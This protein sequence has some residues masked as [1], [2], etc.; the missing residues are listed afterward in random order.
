VPDVLEAVDVKG[1]VLIDCTNAI[2]QGEW[3]LA[4]PEMAKDVAAASDARVVKAFN[5]CP[6]Q[7]WRTTPVAV[8]LCGDDPD[9]LAI[10]RRLVSDIGC[11][12]LDGGGLDRAAL[13]EAT[14]AVVIGLAVAGKDLRDALG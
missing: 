9:A 10:V 1:K 8:P 13:L 7:T 14:A 2:V 5:L 11:E 6:D 12:P 4:V 3:T